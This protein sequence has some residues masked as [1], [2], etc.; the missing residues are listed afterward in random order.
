MKEYT[1]EEILKTYSMISDFSE[2]EECSKIRLALVQ[3]K[4]FLANM[5]CNKVNNEK[6]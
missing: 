5:Y 2:S 6:I 4:N 3:I 1:K